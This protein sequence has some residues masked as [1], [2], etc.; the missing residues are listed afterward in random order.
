MVPTRAKAVLAGLALVATAGLTS[1]A[2]A[3]PTPAAAPPFR[4]ALIGDSGYNAQGEAN[5]LRVRNSINASG[6]A[7]TVHD[8]DIWM[9][10]TACTDERLQ[11]IKSIFNTFGTLV[12][13]PGDNEWV[14]C[15]RTDGRL[16]AI[17]RTFFASDR[18]LGGTPIL[19]RRQAGTPENARWEWGGIVF[20]TLNVPGPSG[21]GPTT[22]ADLAWLDSTF[23]R[24][25]AI[26]APAVM[27]IW[28]DDPTDGS[29]PAL[30]AKLR[31]RSAAFGKPVMLVHGDTH[32]YKLDNPWRDVPNLTRLETFPTFTPEWVKVIVDPAGPRVFTVARLRG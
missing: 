8:G 30:V 24:A 19:Q 23:D 17:R 21:G 25:A 6:V 20:A 2:R 27:V 1:V 12:Y 11:R 7:F 3:A 29:S 22:T 28:Q 9:G 5:F 14:D 15:P 16:P 32:R 10:G 18:S 13:T 31:Q 26:R 4:I